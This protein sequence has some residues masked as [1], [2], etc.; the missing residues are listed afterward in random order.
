MWPLRVGANQNS[1]Y[2]VIPAKFASKCNKNLYFMTINNAWLESSIHF[3]W[4]PEKKLFIQLT[5]MQMDNYQMCKYPCLFYTHP[6]PTIDIFKINQ[7]SSN[8]C[9]IR[10]ITYHRWCNWWTV[11]NAY[12][13]LSSWYRSKIISVTPVKKTADNTNRLVHNAS[14]LGIM[15]LMVVFNYRV[16]IQWFYP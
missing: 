3:R 2:R 14:I 1:E 6:W 15:K 7:N 11:V 5:I 13:C 16:T 8:A 12:K 9:A 10:N 4:S